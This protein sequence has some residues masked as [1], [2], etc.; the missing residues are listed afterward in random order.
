MTTATEAKTMKPA[1][2]AAEV[3]AFGYAVTLK[4]LAAMSVSDR[5]A[6]IEFIDI[7]QTLGREN[8]D[9][10]DVLAPFHH[11]NITAANVRRR[12]KAAIQKAAAASTPATA[13]TEQAAGNSAEPYRVL[14]SVDHISVSPYQ[15]R[16]EFDRAKLK[17]LGQSL[18]EQGQL[19]DLLVRIRP[20]YR[21]KSTA[22]QYEL[23]GGER[24]WRAAQLA[25]IPELWCR[26]VAADNDQARKMATF[27]NFDREDLTPLERIQAYR[28]L[29][30]HG[31][32]ATQKELA[33]AIGIKPAS[34]S[35]QLRIL[36]LP[37]EWHERISQEKFG[38]TITHLRYLVPWKDRQAVLDEVWSIVEDEMQWSSE[39]GD[40]LLVSDFSH[41]V[42]QAVR[43]MSR[44]LDSTEFVRRQDGCQ[45][46]GYLTHPIAKKFRDDP[47]LDVQTVKLGPDTEK[48]AFNIPLW[49]Q[50][51]EQSKPKKKKP[52]KAADSGG[53]DAGDWNQK[54]SPGEAKAKAE[55]AAEKLQKKL[56]RWKLSV[57]QSRISKRFA[58]VGPGRLDEQPIPFAEIVL[59]HLLWFCCQS[60]SDAAY[61]RRN[62]LAAAIE[63]AGGRTKRDNANFVNT[64]DV[65]GSLMTL[66]P[67]SEGRSDLFVMVCHTLST[68][69]QAPCEG[70]HRD[71]TPEAIEHAAEQ[72]GIS[73]TDPWELTREFLE[74]HSIAGLTDLA[75][76]W[77]YQFGPKV[78]GKASMIAHLLK[79]C[80][81]APAPKCV[82]KMKAVKL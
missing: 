75:K 16:Q 14:V 28:Q 47:E 40:T 21:G 54:L 22:Q 5:N 53:D 67:G 49:E 42:T 50:C 59:Q 12:K 38:L 74:L 6:V 19:T 63:D 51:Y 44:P 39:D 56:Y 73:I 70:Y 3:A 9:V 45:V 37:T 72:L 41:Y 43:D 29:L 30:E 27:D 76:E 20:G 10:P 80:S 61:R 58:D 69:W 66:Q 13:T 46:H 31:V 23:I 68:W 48:R 2:I 17:Q 8:A 11:T 32:Y 1:E 24:R 65:F 26:V 81:D 57:L 78:S 18:K 33:K 52:G 7:A 36:D 64:L 15:P 82:T 77:K 25:G 71:V 79:Q 55:A 60:D 34:L 35:N 62:E 4:E